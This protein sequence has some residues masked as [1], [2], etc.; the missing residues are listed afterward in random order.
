LDFGRSEYI[1]RRG[2]LSGNEFIIIEEGIFSA[3]RDTLF[4]VPRKKLV[5]NVFIEN[6]TEYSA[7]NHDNGIRIR[8]SYSRYAYNYIDRFNS[9]L[10]CS[11]TLTA[12]EISYFHFEQRKYIAVDCTY[13]SMANNCIFLL[14]L[15]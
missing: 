15:F 10:V 8:G 14:P 4:L 3:R 5:P 12:Y 1:L 11:D 9:T 2:P 7:P 6:D 13:S